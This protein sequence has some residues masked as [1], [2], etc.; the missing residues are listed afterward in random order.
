MFTDSARFRRVASG[1]PLIVAPPPSFLTAPGTWG[2]DREEW[3][4]SYPINRPGRTTPD[5]YAN[6]TA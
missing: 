4:S 2:D 1:T 5:S 3:V 6:T